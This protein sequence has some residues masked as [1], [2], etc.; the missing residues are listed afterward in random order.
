MH[1]VQHVERTIAVDAPAGDTVATAGTAAETEK[2]QSPD[3][4]EIFLT[5]RNKWRYT[6]QRLR[7]DVH[8]SP[9][10]GPRIPVVRL[11]SPPTHPRIPGDMESF[12]PLCAIGV[13]EMLV[14]TGITDFTLPLGIKMRGLEGGTY[15]ARLIS[16]DAAGVNTVLFAVTFTVRKAVET[17]WLLP[18]RDV[19]LSVFHD[20]CVTV[21]RRTAAGET[22]LYESAPLRIRTVERERRQ[23]YILGRT[24]TRAIDLACAAAAT[25]ALILP[26]GLI[27]WHVRRRVVSR[28]LELAADRAGR[29][30]SKVL[31]Y[32]APA[33]FCDSSRWIY[34]SGNLAPG[35]VLKLE[36]LTPS[37][38][39][40]AGRLSVLLR[41]LA[42]DEWPQLLLLLTG[43]WS[44]FGPR[45]YPNRDG[46]LAPDGKTIQNSR[47]L[48]ERYVISGVA[49]K[50]GALS[51]RVAITPRGSISL[52]PWP[53]SVLYDYY[54]SLHWSVWHACRVVGRLALTFVWGEAVTEH[55]GPVEIRVPEIHTRSGTGL[56]R[57]SMRGTAAAATVDI[58]ARMVARGV[59][60]FT[61]HASR[62]GRS[63]NGVHVP[64]QCNEES[65]T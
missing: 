56:E 64:R 55:M 60:M 50:P 65:L 1:H 36:T 11:Y 32:I 5:P 28:H 6:L 61:M 29:C 51:T 40:L 39:P 19:R 17:E 34:R 23:H 53:T 27:A 52:P 37:K 2:A 48:R 43:A 30:Q 25:A 15:D 63:C 9:G 35:T 3:R 57:P 42:I 41:Q 33:F 20:L 4:L 10:F 24:G 7:A 38:R 62:R 31:R 13:S 14:E 22:P 59:N 12:A 8:L 45:A 18:A 47:D 54:D 16:I 21:S 46:L 49:R 26:F 58:S 44:L